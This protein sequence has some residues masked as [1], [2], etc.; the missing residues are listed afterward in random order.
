MVETD[1]AIL[2][3]TYMIVSVQHIT[4]YFAGTKA[5][6]DVS[7][8]IPEG[9]I[10]GL[11]GPNGAGKTTCIRILNQMI[12]PDAGEITID[13]K[14][15]R[16]S[17]VERIGYLPEE[18]GLYKKMR[19]AEQILYFASLKNMDKNHAKQELEFWLE[20]LEIGSWRNKRIEE[21]S[22]G[23]QQKVQFIATVLHKPSLLILDEPFS[24]FDPVNAQA[25]K[26]EVIR[27]K[28]EGT[29]I[30][31]STHNMNSVE[32]LCDRIS[33]IHKSKQILNGAVG[34]IRNSFAGNTYEVAFS[35]YCDTL[36]TTLTPSLK[37]LGKQVDG[38]LTKLQIELMP[39]VSTNDAIQFLMKSG[40]IVSFQQILPSMNDIF[41]QAVEQHN[42][43]EHGENV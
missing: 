2:R 28:N 37:I 35:G 11:L 39:Q 31:L 22:K 26:N 32:E 21:L 10:Y 34:D 14:Q 7:F 15:L 36:S 4:K 17:D 33:L 41:I 16:E 5:L 42:K 38:N 20:K 40:S 1:S 8:E 3:F 27:L 23:M 25:I 43:S 12:R 24:G 13:G 19:V 6:D 9:S 30:L 29:T 18:R